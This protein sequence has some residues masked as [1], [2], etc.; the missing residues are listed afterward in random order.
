MLLRSS[1][2]PIPN[3]LLPNSWEY[4]SPDPEVTLHLPRTLASSQQEIIVEEQQQKVY[5]KTP[6]VWKLFSASGLN[7]QF[8][9]HQ[10]ET[11]VMGDGMGS[12]GG[13]IYGGRD[14]GGGH[15][16]DETD[17]YYKNMIEINPNNA[18]LLANYAK[19]LK[20]VIWFGASSCSFSL[21]IGKFLK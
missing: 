13:K 5:N 16:K 20:E 8:L 15:G 9:D 18:L 12:N 4:S 21:K 3:S 2:A 6:S 17:A 7:K 19:F 1:S 10:E 11:L 14:T